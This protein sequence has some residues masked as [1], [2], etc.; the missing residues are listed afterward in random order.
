MRASLT[1]IKAILSAN[2]DYF[3]IAA[4]VIAIAFGVGLWFIKHFGLMFHNPTFN[5]VWLIAFVTLIFVLPIYG[6]VSFHTSRLGSGLRSVELDTKVMKRSLFVYSGILWASL[7]WL[8]IGF[9][10]NDVNYLLY[11]AS[12]VIVLSWY[13]IVKLL[14]RYVFTL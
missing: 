11:T 6:Y 14:V 4:V 13:A 9:L 10:L 5:A 2:L 1:R 7:A 8:V 3:V 12:V